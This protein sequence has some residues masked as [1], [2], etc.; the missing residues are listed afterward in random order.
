L[1][2]L[3]RCQRAMRLTMRQMRSPYGTYR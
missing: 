1:P 3:T 2:L